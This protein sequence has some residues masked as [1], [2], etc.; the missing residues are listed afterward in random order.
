MLLRTEIIAANDVRRIVINYRES[1]TPGYP[2]TGFSVSSNSTTSSVGNTS[3]DPDHLEAV[4][5]V[6]AG[7]IGEKFVVAVQAST[8]DGQTFNDVINITVLAPVSVYV[9][10]PVLPTGPGGPPGS[11]GPVGPSGGSTGPT[12]L[13]GVQG[14][15][16]NA[17][18]VAPTG[19]TGMSGA[20]G[21]AGGTGST[22]PIGAAG[23]A[24]ATGNTGLTG[25]GGTAGPT[26]STGS[27][28]S[29]GVAGATGNT[30]PTGPTGPTSAT[31][32]TGGQLFPLPNYTAGAFYDG[33]GSL[34][35]CP[36]SIVNATTGVTGSLYLCPFPVTSTFT[37]DKL[38]VN[39]VIAG[40]GGATS[41]YNLG[42]Y[43]NSASNR[44]STLLA[45][46]GGSNTT[47]VG[48]I[49]LPLGTNLQLTPGVYWFAYQPGDGTQRFQAVN[50]LRTAPN[51]KI[52]A[53]GAAVTGNAAVFG[54][55]PLD[56]SG[57]YCTGPTGQTAVNVPTMPTGL[58]GVGATLTNFFG[59][60]G[61]G[62]GGPIPQFHI[63]SIP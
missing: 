41:F 35:C 40:G 24:G 8:M 19:P 29:Q 25:P 34:W 44:P 3:F 61:V 23:D 1:L 9:A 20:V 17:G 5:Y 12:G 27:T 26:G 56:S 11:A 62:S 60:G 46:C 59:L 47:S 7:A 22:G 54:T 38:S 36:G 52:T 10:G 31:G 39:I 30:G 28:G 50:A 21:G 18:G 13:T 53:L 4:F 57:F 63:V 15:P 33:L 55:D 6:T 42:I 49:Y 37:I 14:A 16:G 48:N 2:L 32:A 43:S 45:I 51:F 58:G